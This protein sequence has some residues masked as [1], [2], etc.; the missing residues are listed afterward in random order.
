MDRVSEDCISNAAR[1]HIDSLGMIKLETMP[2]VT[3]RGLVVIAPI[4]SIHP[5]INARP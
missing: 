4:C 2:S 5:P 3:R 1:R